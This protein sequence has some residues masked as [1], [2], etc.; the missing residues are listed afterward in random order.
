[1]D[2]HT[3]EQKRENMQAIKSKDSEIEILLRKELWSRGLRYR[4]MQIKYSGSQILF[5]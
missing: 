4:K 2:R 5:L 3:P 1:M